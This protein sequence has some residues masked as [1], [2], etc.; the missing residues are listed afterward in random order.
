MLYICEFEI[1]NSGQ[2]VCAIPC[3]DMGAGTFGDDFN[4][5]VES[6]ADWLM[7][8]VDDSLMNG[9]ELPSVTLDHEPKNGGK[10]VAI[11]VSR[12]LSDIPAM[13]AEDA[14]RELGVS[15]A[16]VAQLCEEGLLDSWADGARRMVSRASVEARK[17]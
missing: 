5:A 4:D 1:F 15:G 9:T 13:T 12:S 7:C 8:M 2:S 11:A 6:A 16:R 3:N 14:A 10:V 17:E